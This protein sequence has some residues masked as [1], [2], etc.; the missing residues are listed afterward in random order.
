MNLNTLKALFEPDPEIQ[1]LSRTI[2]GQPNAYQDFKHIRCDIFRRVV[3]VDP[4]L[5]ETWYRVRRC[6]DGSRPY[7]A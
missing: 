5:P 3:R 6:S 1:N 4:P 2:P 7:R